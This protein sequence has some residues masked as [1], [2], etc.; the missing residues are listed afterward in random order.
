MNQHQLD[1]LTRYVK[2]MAEEERTK[3]LRKHLVKELADTNQ[4]HSQFSDATTQN[5]VRIDSSKKH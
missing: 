3:D 1:A 4:I 5:V 2:G